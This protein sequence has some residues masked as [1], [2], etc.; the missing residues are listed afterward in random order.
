MLLELAQAMIIAKNI[1]VFLWDKAVMH[2]A[3]LQNCV[4]T[5]ASN[6]KTPYEPWT[7]DNP[8]VPHF[9]EF[10]CDVWVLDETRNCS[11]LAT[12]SNKFIFIGFHNGLKS[13][14]YY[15]AKTQPIQVS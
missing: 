8:H 7:G 10:R 4:P 12:K 14:P 9:S 5:H 6:G 11:K 15:D 13:V 2:V 1:L 3:Y